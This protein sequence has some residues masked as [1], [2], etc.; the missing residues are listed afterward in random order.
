MPT[1]T[2]LDLLQ[3][4]AGELNLV[5]IGDSLAAGSPMTQRLL[6]RLVM[7]VDSWNLKPTVVPWYDQHV[8]NLAP[9]K[10]TYLIGPN[11][12]D[13]NAPTPIRLNPDA[14]NLL[15][16]NPVAAG[17]P[18]TGYYPEFVQCNSIFIGGP[19]YSFLINSANLGSYPVNLLVNWQGPG[20]S[21]GSYTAAT[22]IR[23]PLAVLSV[24]QWAN[25]SLPYLQNSYPSGCYLDG[26]VVTGTNGGQPYTASRI[27]VWG[28]P[29]V[30]NQIEF[31]YWHAIT[32][33][34]LTDPVNV[35]AGYFRAMVLNLAVEIAPGFGI[36]INALTLKNAADA[37]GDIKELNAPDMTMRIDR[38]MPGSKYA[39]YI[40][41]AQFLSGNF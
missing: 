8:F 14:T 1:S 31:F 33:G 20:A 19:P 2:Y 9:G 17:V 37:L 30:V 15:L 26:S 16:T 11:A 4:A 29:T 18:G 24:E 38:G 27:S 22:P 5:A 13:W 7:M 10:Q 40:S 35:Q 6:D 25:I 12:P 23:I 21:A 28:I 3:Q 32:A 36:Q 41:K 39:G 34:N